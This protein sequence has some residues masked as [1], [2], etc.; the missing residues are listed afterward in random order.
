MADLQSYLAE[1]QKSSSSL[2][3]DSAVNWFNTRTNSVKTTLH[4]SIKDVKSQ[5]IAEPE[6]ELEPTCYSRSVARLESCLPEIDKTQRF[7]LFVLFLLVSFICFA[8][9]LSMLPLL[10]LQ[11]TKFLL[12]LTF[13]N[14]CSMLAFIVLRGIR[15][16]LSNMF[17]K[18][19]RYISAVYVVSTICTI[20]VVLILQSTP[21]TLVLAIVQVGSIVSY[22]M[23]YLPG[24]S[25]ALT[26]LTSLCSKTT[27]TVAHSM[28]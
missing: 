2:A 16:H 6:P 19:K 15:V 13:G 28:V 5:F 20:Y 17:S 1:Q 7:A 23:S 3:L 8:L 22:F 11:P 12:C 10:I 9:A 24:G 25:T 4:A 14:I 18:E 27:Q 21:L 26:L